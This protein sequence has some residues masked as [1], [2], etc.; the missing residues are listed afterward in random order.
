MATKAGVVTRKTIHG[1][2]IPKALLGPGVFLVI[3]NC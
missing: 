1:T 2:W 3:A